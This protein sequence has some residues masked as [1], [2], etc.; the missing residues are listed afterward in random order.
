M[1]EWL[2]VAGRGHDGHRLCERGGADK[3]T[4]IAPHII[5]NVLLSVRPRRMHPVI[6]HDD[7]PLFE[8]CCCFSTQTCPFRHTMQT[9]V[10]S[11]LRCVHH[12]GCCRV[13]P[14][15]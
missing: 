3:S 1:D 6:S 2:S 10:H 14:G 12:P 8:R 13:G 15:V 9:A 11:S 7:V 5:F 4:R